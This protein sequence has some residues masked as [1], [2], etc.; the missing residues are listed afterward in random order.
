MNNCS[1]SRCTWNKVYRQDAFWIGCTD[2]PRRNIDRR[3]M[4]QDDMDH[5]Y[6]MQKCSLA[7]ILQAT[8]LLTTNDSNVH[9]SLIFTLTLI[10]NILISWHAKICNAC[11]HVFS[12]LKQFLILPKRICIIDHLPFHSYKKGILL[13]LVNL[14]ILVD[15]MMKSP[16]MAALSVID[17]QGRH[18]SLL[19]DIPEPIHHHSIHVGKR[20][21]HCNNPGCNK[22]FTTR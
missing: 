19:N 14:I 16:H 17:A 2:R 8:V 12:M 4:W 11:S 22:S 10:I 7:N 5:Q 20:R 1:S 9:M 18:V 6:R 13:S 15:S 3:V 21:F